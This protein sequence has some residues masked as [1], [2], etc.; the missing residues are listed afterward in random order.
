MGLS[1]VDEIDG[2]DGGGTVEVVVGDS[3]MEA[4]G[5]EEDVFGAAVL[6]DEG[7]VDEAAVATAGFAYF[8]E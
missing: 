8:A 3:V 7:V 1:T 4:L 6:G 2:V 5:S